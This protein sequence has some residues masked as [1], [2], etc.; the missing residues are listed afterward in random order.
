MRTNQYSDASG[1]E[2]RTAL[3]KRR[4]RVVEL[5]AALVVA[6]QLFAERL[7]ELGLVDF[8]EAA[9]QCSRGSRRR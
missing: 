2:P 9:R 4:D 6:A 5:L 1:S 8:L 3:C 7:L